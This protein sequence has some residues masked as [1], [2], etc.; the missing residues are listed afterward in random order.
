[1]TAIKFEFQA[2]EKNYIELIKYLPVNRLLYRLQFIL[3]TLA[4]LTF[5]CYAV[6]IIA[7]DFVEGDNPFIVYSILILFT[8]IL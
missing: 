3:I 7:R 6:Y 2:K 5:L 8:F 1:M 4:T